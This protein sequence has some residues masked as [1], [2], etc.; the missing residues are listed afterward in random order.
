[1][2]ILTDEI[3]LSDLAYGL[4]IAKIICFQKCTDG[5]FMFLELIIELT[6]LV[7]NLYLSV[8]I[9]LISPV[10]ADEIPVERD[11]HA[12]FSNFLQPL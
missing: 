2:V 10:A 4:H 7:E 6:Q 5:V 3:N 12:L 11:G 9:L 8:N 1:M